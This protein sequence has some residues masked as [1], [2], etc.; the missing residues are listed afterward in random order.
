MDL[1]GFN[2]FDSCINSPLLLGNNFFLYCG[3]CDMHG[4]IKGLRFF[5]Q[6]GNLLI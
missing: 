6:N 3:V 1:L 5:K 4:R 2:Y